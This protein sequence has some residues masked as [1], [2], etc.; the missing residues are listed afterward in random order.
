MLEAGFTSVRD[1][2]NEGNYACSS[3]RVAI[4]KGLIPGPTMLNAGRIIAPYGGQFHLQPDRPDIAGKEYFFADT[5]DEMMKGIR[6]NAQFGAKVI[7]IVVDDQPY[8]YSVDDIKFIIEE[9]SRAKLK[10]A[11]H[12]WTTA[13]AHNASLAG[14]ASMEHLNGA[15]EEDMQTAKTNGV[16]AVFT[17][18]PLQE[19]QRFRTPERAQKEYDIE[20]EQLKKGL[21]TGIP[22]AFGTDCTMN[23]VGMTRGQTALQWIDSYVAAGF[24]PAAIVKAMTTNAARLLG[25]DK[26]RGALR[27]GMAAD[28]I[29]TAAN[30]LQHIDTLKAVTFVMKNG[31]V[32][33]AR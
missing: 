13:G 22:V 32:V 18:F 3:V 17:P 23:A 4:D 21:R 8:I 26:D 2:G 1:V 10:V 33:K 15:A 14:V 25:V 31:V 30:P 27:A 28:I 16:T 7:K 11:A 9:A 12:V 29:A 6:E 24:T 19:L 20:Q 5:R